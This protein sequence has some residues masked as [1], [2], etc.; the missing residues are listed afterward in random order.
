MTEAHTYSPYRIDFELIVNDR[1]EPVIPPEG[2]WNSVGVPHLSSNSL[3]TLI[4]TLDRKSTQSTT[5]SSTGAILPITGGDLGDQR[6]ETM[7]VFVET[8]GSPLTVTDT[9]VN[10]ASDW[11]PTP[12]P[13]GL[14]R[15]ALEADGRY[16]YDQTSQHVLGKTL[17]K[18]R[19]L[20]ALGWKMLSVSYLQFSTCD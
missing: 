5:K 4:H 11:S 7:P 20:E 16:H 15:V 19:Q 12:L 10:L 14:H 9:A 13:E 17:L 18:K 3:D 6:V 1:G 8:E 2:T